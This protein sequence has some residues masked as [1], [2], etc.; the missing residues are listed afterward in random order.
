MKKLL[1]ITMA[2]LMM[3]LGAVCSASS[4]EQWEQIDESAYIDVNSIKTFMDGTTEYVKG[5]IKLNFSDSTYGIYYYLVDKDTLR[6]GLY[7]TEKYDANGTLKS[8]MEFTKSLT[9]DGTNNPIIKEILKRA[10]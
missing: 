4:G 9:H 3:T 1:I 2:I 7:L 8:K 10:N 5:R 6:F